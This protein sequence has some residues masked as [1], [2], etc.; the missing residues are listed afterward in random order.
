VLITVNVEMI[1]AV[2]TTAAKMTAIS[3]VF[4]EPLFLSIVVLLFPKK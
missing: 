2:I 1:P 4:K 3:T